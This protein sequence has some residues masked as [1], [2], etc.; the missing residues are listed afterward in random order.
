MESGSE[1][2]SFLSGKSSN[3]VDRTKRKKAFIWSQDQVDYFITGPMRAMNS[4][5][6]RVCS[7]AL[8]LSSLPR[9]AKDT[10]L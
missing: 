7:W 10:N 1:K 8:E 4:E 9:H 2:V 3:T 6:T 5:G